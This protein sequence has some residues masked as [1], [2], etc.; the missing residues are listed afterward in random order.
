MTVSTVMALNAEPQTIILKG[1]PVEINLARKYS[2]G[3]W[4]A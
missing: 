4:R 2:I 1:P 3:V